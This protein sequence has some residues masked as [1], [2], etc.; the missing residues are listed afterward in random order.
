MKN[1][2]FFEASAAMA[3]EK[4]VP[5]ETVYEAISKSIIT[6][7]KNDYGDRDIVFCDINPEKQTIKVYIRKRVVET[8]EDPIEEISLEEAQQK[9]KR[10]KVGDTVDIELNSKAVSRKAAQKGKHTL[11]QNVTEAEQESKRKELQ[12][13]YHELATVKV[14]RIDPLTLD[15][16]VEIGKVIERLPRSEQL[17]ND[18]FREGEYIKV[19][20]TD[21]VESQKGGPKAKITRLK[22]DFVKRLLELEVPEII[23]GTVEI[24]SVAR[25][26][27]SRTKVAVYSSDENV[28]PV[29]ACIGPRGQRINNIVNVLAGEKIDVIIYS[30]DLAE[31]VKA[32][33]APADVISVS[34]LVPEEKSCRAIVPNN[35]LSLAI[36]NKGQNARLAA[37]LTGAKIDIKPE[38]EEPV[39]NFDE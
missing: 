27:G 28:D 13:K 21:V 15:A 29:G 9:K 12:E 34:V 35:Q 11:R 14:N 3:A 5:V 37:R 22:E 18:V 2:D 31:F 19:Y 36:G 38:F 26:A 20:V 8:V 39:I 7:V 4:G 24:R 10:I 17:P 16:F 33:L 23:D 32:A 30:D 6:S 25:E 1:A